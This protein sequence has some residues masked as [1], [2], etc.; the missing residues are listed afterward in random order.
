[1]SYLGEDFSLQFQQQQLEIERF[2]ALHTERLRLE[3]ESRRRRSSRRIAAAVVE[4]VSRRLKAKEEEIEKIGKLNWV[5]EER[6]KSLSLE[7]QIWKDLAQTNEA[8]A[9]AL[10]CN[11][12]QLL[13]QVHETSGAAAGDDDAESCCGSTAGD[14]N[15]LCRNC[16]ETESCVLLL[17]CRHLCLCDACASSTNACP[18]CQ[19]LKTGSIHVNLT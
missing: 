6:V 1:L 14:F 17:P 4:N 16:C 7:N 18:V 12:Q 13:S 11:L 5:L 15:R 8:T 19:A 10:R 9:N 3:M 2:V